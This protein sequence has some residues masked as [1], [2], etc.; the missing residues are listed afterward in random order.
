MS[1]ALLDHV[2]ASS[3]RKKVPA[4]KPGCSVAVFHKIKEGDKERVQIFKGLVIRVNSGTGVDKTFTVRKVVQGIGVEKI[5]PFHAATIEKVELIKQ[6]KVRRAKL[7]FM[8]KLQ[9]KSTRLRDT[10]LKIAMID[11]ETPVE[12]VEET[13]VAEEAPVVEEA[14]VAEET[15]EEK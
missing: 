1:R 12:I 3:L 10:D 4:L 5:F 14:A 11:D 7:Y 13:P 6:G 8:R 15:A 2:T 9:G